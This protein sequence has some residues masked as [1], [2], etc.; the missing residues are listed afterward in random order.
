VHT[1]F[2]GKFN[3]RGFPT[4]KMF[5]AGK[6]SLEDAVEYDG[7]R[8]AS[9]IVSW[10]LAKVAENVPAPELIEVSVSVYALF[11]SFIQL[12]NTE[13]LKTACDNRQLCVISILPQL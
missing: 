6:K 7:G 12:T 5:P 9:D 10:A 4:I 2:S 3:V 8:T 13:A 11:L 1:I